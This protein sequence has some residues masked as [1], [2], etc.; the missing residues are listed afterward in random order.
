MHEV[1]PYRPSMYMEAESARIGSWELELKAVA[2]E[3][4]KQ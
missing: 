3:I 4:S 1:L 2:F